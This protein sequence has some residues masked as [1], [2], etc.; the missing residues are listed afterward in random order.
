MLNDISPQALETLKNRIEEKN[1]E[2]FEYDVS[3]TF[4][5]KCDVWFDRAVLH[6][7]LSEEEKNIY[8]EN[9][10]NSLSK[11]GYVLFS[12]FAK[13]DVKYCANLP[14]EHYNVEKFSSLLGDGFKLIDNEVFEYTMPWED[15]RLYLYVL[16]KRI[17]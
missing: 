7:L 10:K 5:K 2:F 9:L 12:E 17:S 13:Q 14:L 15:T 16:F 1:V 3:K 8:F 4:Q 11:G 6:F